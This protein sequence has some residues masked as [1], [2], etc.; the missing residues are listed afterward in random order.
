MLQTL[1]QGKWYT[2]LFWKSKCCSDTQLGVRLPFNCLVK[3]TLKNLSLGKGLEA[4]GVLCLSP[5][6][7]PLAAA[8]LAFG[9]GTLLVEPGVSTCS[10][11]QHRSSR[12]KQSSA[13]PSCTTSRACNY[14]NSQPQDPDI[15]VVP[16]SSSSCPPFPVMTPGLV[17]LSQEPIW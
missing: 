5:G 10:S 13:G 17:N 15:I 6:L 14:K 2:S 8:V 16:W 11:F 3:I 12:R 9:K 7:D 4:T 1:Q